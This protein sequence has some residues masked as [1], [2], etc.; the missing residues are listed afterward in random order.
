MKSPAAGFLAQ[1]GVG[2]GSVALGQLLGE[3]GWAAVTR[4][5]RDPMAPKAPTTRPKPRTSSFSSWLGRPSHLELLDHKPQ[6]TRFDGTL[7]P[8][9]L[10]KGYRAAFID[11]HSKLLGP[12]FKYSRQ[13]QCNAEISECCSP[14]QRRR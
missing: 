1:C 2:L 9:E 4:D 6:L 14:W 13:G 3:T 11:P 7:P 8:A 5:R 12:K 10:L